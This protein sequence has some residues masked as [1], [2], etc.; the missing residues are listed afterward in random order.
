MHKAADTWAGLAL[1]R[2]RAIRCDSKFMMLMFNTTKMR[3]TAF[4]LNDR[5]QN[6][7]LTFIKRLNLLVSNCHP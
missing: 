3:I 4:L 2:L 5:C 7:A 1:G 6:N